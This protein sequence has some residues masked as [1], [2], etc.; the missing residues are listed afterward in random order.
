MYLVYIYRGISQRVDD[1]PE[2]SRDNLLICPE[3]IIGTGWTHGL[4]LL[5]RQEPLTSKDVLP[6]HCFER[7]FGNP[8]G[9]SFIGYIDEYGRRLRKRTEPRTPSGLGSSG[10]LAVQVGAA[11]GLPPPPED[12]ST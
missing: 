12:A 8:D 7:G 6:V 2:L 3:M 10:S 4:F 11:L 5:V 9:T 1:V